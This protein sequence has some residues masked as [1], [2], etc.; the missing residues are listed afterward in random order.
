MSLSIDRSIYLTRNKSSVL[1][2]PKN[3]VKIESFLQQL[4]D[5][6]TELKSLLIERTAKQKDFLERRRQDPRNLRLSFSKKK[7]ENL[8]PQLRKMQL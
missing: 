6:S 5:L 3:Y 1:R 2:L 4:F 7:S 8:L